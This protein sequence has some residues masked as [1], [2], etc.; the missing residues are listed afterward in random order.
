M[1]IF[2]LQSPASSTKRARSE[3]SSRDHDGDSCSDSD[4]DD[5]EDVWTSLPLADD[6]EWYSLELGAISHDSLL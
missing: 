1:S 2:Y 3:K 5:D 6:G 4:D